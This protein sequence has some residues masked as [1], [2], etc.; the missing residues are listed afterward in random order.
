LEKA[1][2]DQCDDEFHVRVTNETEEIKK[3][4]E[5]GFKCVCEKDGFN[6]P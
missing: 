3:L 6:I 2:F 1:I 4:L 5:V